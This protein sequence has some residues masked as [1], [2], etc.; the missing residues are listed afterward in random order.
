MQ[1]LWLFPAQLWEAGKERETEYQSKSHR[2]DMI[3]KKTKSVHKAHNV[4]D[5]ITYHHQ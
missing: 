4:Q 1:I 2:V 5:T 3:A